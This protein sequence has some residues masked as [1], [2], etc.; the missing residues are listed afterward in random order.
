MNLSISTLIRFRWLL[1]VLSLALMAFALAGFKQFVFDAS[2]RIYF[3][4]G[5]QP[6]EDYL[7]LEDTY[8]RDFKVFF[9][10]SASDGDDLFAPQHLQALL[11]MT[12]QAWQLPFV[13]RVDSLS[14]FQYSHNVD[15]EL[16]IEDLVSS[17]LLDDAGLR[18]S[19]RAYALADPDIQ[20]RLLTADGRHA[21]LTLSLS[22]TGDQAQG[23]AAHQ[24]VTEAYALEERIKA[25]YPG[26]DIAVTGN[27]LSTYH[28]VKVAERDI[29]LMVPVM[30]GLMFV[31]LGLLFRSVS[32][33]LVALVIAV[34]AAVG[35]LGLAAWCNITF[36]M[37]AINAL[38]ISITVAV[39][40][41]IH[42]F[43]QLFQALKTRDKMAALEDSLR[44]NFFAVSMTSLTTI[45]G[46][47]SLNTNDL[48]PAVAL[49]NAAAIGT[50]LAWLFSLTLLPALVS[51]L[52]FRAHSGGEYAIEGLMMKLARVV[53]R[54]KYPVLLGMSLL[55]VLMVQLSF[56]NELNDRLT[57]TLHEPHIFRTDNGL[58][59]QHFGAMYVNNYEMDAGEENGIADPA[60]LKAMEKMVDY[61]RAQ[62]EVSSVY[63]FTDVIKRLHRSMH[64]D[65]PAYYTIP[66]DRDLIAQYILLYEMS[67]P[68]GLDLNNQ[69]TLDKRKSIVIVSTPSQD[70]R[71]NIELDQR[72][73]AWIAA[74]MP[75][76]LQANNISLSTI[77]SYLTVHS[78]QNSLE[79]SI[80][81]LVLISLV[82]LFMLRSLRYGVISL[83]PNIM[84]AA[85]GFGFW[86]LYSGDVGLG[87]T[88]VVIITIGIVVDDTVHFLVKYQK[89]LRDNGGDAEKAV[90]A[91]FR[92]VGPALLITTVVLAAGFLVLA[93]SAIIINSALGQ[94]TAAI[95]L[96]A[97]LLDVLLLPALLLVV[98]GR[99]RQPAAS[100]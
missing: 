4:K 63:S 33:V 44:I 20:G 22:M 88:C 26:V 52:P 40:H 8:G 61:L 7:A 84:P 1:F 71:S 65:D 21:S 42:I 94:V 16:V 82:L 14:N 43:T 57:E 66:D 78:L 74:N 59:D 85:F 23:Q 50:A 90:L 37:L 80:V 19:R 47:L 58:I 13:R 76:H 46:F 30:F 79:G 91:T 54:R 15:D 75:A 17:E 11:E 96:A 45:I 56:S 51:I 55:T 69:I 39:A 97:F 10:L 35:A 77:W 36:S 9:M 60:Y 12:E 29:A 31:F 28:N 5:F 67:V 41:C 53:V 68:F 32:A 25:R 34:F 99:R 3:E 73:N 70:T 48:P 64:N 18:A 95:L 6:Y 89:A 92:L 49:G 93:M 24:L 83:I 100:G 2:P 86:Y 38:I 81:A 62:P 72:V 98:D 27:L 87:L